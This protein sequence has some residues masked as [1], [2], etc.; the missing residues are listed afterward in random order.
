M[1]Y[2]TALRTDSWLA[3]MRMGQSMQ[4]SGMSAGV[5]LALILAVCAGGARAHNPHQCPGDFPD[6][7]AIAGHV[8]QGDIDS[9]IYSFR[10]VFR[11]GRQLFIANW[12]RCDGQGRPATTGT[13]DARVADEPDFIRTSGP[14]SNSCAGCHNAPRAGGAGDFVAN[15]F[16]LAQALDPV[17]TSL[18][19]EFSNERNTLGMFGAG[20][21]E[22]LAREMTAELQEASA[23]LV[24]GEYVLTAKGVPFEVTISGGEVIASRGIDPDL[25]VKPFH[26]AGVVRSLR[27]FTVNAFNHHHGMQAEERFDL[28]PEQGFNPDHDQD[29]VTRELT[30]GDITAATVFQAALAV[31]GR[32]LPANP[33]TRRQVE[34]GE[35]LF[36]EV[37]CTVC[38]IPALYLEDRHFVEPYPLNPAGTLSSGNSFVFDLTREGEKPRLERSGQ[39]GAIV[40]AYTDLKRHN[41]CDE[42]IRVLCN[43]Q[44]AQGRKDQD[45]QPG[46]EF[47]ITRKLWDVGNSAPYGH[48]GDLTTLTEAILAHGGEAR[49]SRDEFVRL[50]VGEQRSVIRFL[51]SFQVLPGGSPRNLVL[52]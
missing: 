24:D 22:M 26:Q 51:R 21:I 41:L 40:R 5:F 50:S 44:L 12:N 39:K 2:L 38:H 4:L 47:F 46:T 45:G 27:E 37:G 14:D 8:E 10:E 17:V 49:E 43:E 16:V 3:V 7:P 33:D 36:H 28:N 23:L 35:L 42:E 19:P 11:H 25:I 34:Q 30:T 18:N 20:A 32:V 1:R 13:G 52:P 9:K 15:V 48:R 6:L 31:P 29:G